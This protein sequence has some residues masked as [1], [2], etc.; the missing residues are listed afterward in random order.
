M[1]FNVI[2]YSSRYDLLIWAFLSDLQIT[3]LSLS[4]NAYYVFSFDSICFLFFIL[5]CLFQN[6]TCAAGVHHPKSWGFV[7]LLTNGFVLWRLCWNL[8]MYV[9]Y[10]SRRLIFGFIYEKNLWFIFFSLA[11]T[12]FQYKQ[13]DLV[14]FLD[15]SFGSDKRIYEVKYLCRILVS[16]IGWRKMCND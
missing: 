16:Q 13:E 15:R 2:L 4:F 10:Q 3:C 7:A 1:S 9:H 14:S 11:E 12:L 8:T 6:C 5:S